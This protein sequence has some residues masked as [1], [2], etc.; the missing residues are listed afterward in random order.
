MGVPLVSCQAGFSRGKTKAAVATGFPAARGKAAMWE[1]GVGKTKS[2][3][4]GVLKV[5]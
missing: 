5:I 1:D 3:P 2:T 4:E